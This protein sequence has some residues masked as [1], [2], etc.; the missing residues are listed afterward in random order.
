[1]L[2]IPAARR[3]S[4]HV[5]PAMRV[6]PHRA[7]RQLAWLFWAYLLLIATIES[8][9]VVSDWHIGLLLYM[10]LL[11][12]LMLHASLGWCDTARKLALALT[13][14]PLV[15]M[16][17]LA[18]PLLHVP[19]LAWL[20]LVI[21]PMLIVV[22]VMTRQLALPTSLLGLRIRNRAFHL[23]MMSGGLGLGTAW[24]VIFQ[25]EHVGVVLVGE[26]A[27]AA[28]WL[29][30][31]LVVLAGFV[32]EMILRGLVQSAA[33]LS[34]GRMALLY[35]A[36][37]SAVLHIGYLSTTVVAFA[38]L[39]GFLFAYLFHWS[40]SLLG[41]G[42]LHGTASATHLIVLPTFLRTVEQSESTRAWM[43]FMNPVEPVLLL[44][45]LALM[46]LTLAAVLAVIGYLCMLP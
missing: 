40:G 21:L 12:S 41:V 2:S 35:S 28:W 39:I 5:R 42:L 22:W 19:L 25:A 4:A 29:L 13:T 10:A 15:R 27:G 23:M 3:R 24:Y 34:M 20:P 18:L 37:M 7:T 43:A 31:P 30:L 9:T 17:A 38:F 11:A 16:I 46:L 36:L 14:V 26:G 6:Q 32:E 8:I 1:M 33:W 44:L 45:I